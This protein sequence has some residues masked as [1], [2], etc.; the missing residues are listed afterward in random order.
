MK[1]EREIPC[2]CRMSMSR[3]PLKDFLTKNIRTPNPGGRGRGFQKQIQVQIIDIILS[4][5]KK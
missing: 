5:H 1:K 2:T 3:Q 4:L